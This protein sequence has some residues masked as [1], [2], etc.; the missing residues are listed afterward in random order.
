MRKTSL[1]ALAVLLVV[2]CAWGLTGTDY[3]EA[4][5]D[6]PH[7]VHEDF[8]LP[9][10]ADDPPMMVAQVGDMKHDL[11]VINAMLADR[12]AVQAGVVPADWQPPPLEDYESAAEPF[13]GEDGGF[14]I[15]T[16]SVDSGGLGG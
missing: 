4:E 15:A 13:V 1:A 12:V 5:S 2:A 11:A 16:G 10:Y 9:S 14:S 8:A 7:E 6:R 3:A